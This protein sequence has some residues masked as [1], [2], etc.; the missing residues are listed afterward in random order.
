VT[1]SD[2]DGTMAGEHR[3]ILVEKVEEWRKKRFGTL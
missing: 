1:G 2:G 3:L